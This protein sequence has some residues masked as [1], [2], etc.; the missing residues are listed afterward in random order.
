MPGQCGQAAA[1]L[2][3]S[4]RAADVACLLEYAQRELHTLAQ[5][6]GADAI[7]DIDMVSE[8]LLP[9]MN[10]VPSK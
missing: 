8:C 5:Y 3:D 7:R 10:R 4:G 2:I 9:S 6:H 1:R